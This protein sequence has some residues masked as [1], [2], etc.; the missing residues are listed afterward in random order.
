MMNRLN[1]RVDYSG[2]LSESVLATLLKFISFT[3][4]FKKREEELNMK[5]K[6]K[7]KQYTV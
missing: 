1:L 7:E 3:L 6:D 2:F 4:Y 5:K